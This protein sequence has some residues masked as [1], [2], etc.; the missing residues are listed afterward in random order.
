M[1][2]AQVAVGLEENNQV[3]VV[4]LSTRGSACSAALPS[5]VKFV[6]RIEAS[7]LTLV[8]TEA[9]GLAVLD[10]SGTLRYITSVSTANVARVLHRSRR[11][12]V[13]TRS[14]SLQLVDLD[15]GVILKDAERHTLQVLDLYACADDS[16][17]ISASQDW[18][19]CISTC[20]DLS[21]VRVLLGHQDGVKACVAVRGGLF[22]TSSYDRLLKVWSPFEEDCRVTLPKQNGVVVALASHPSRD[23]FASG[24]H[25][26]AV[27][28]WSLTDWS[29]VRS[30]SLAKSVHSLAFAVSQD[31]VLAGVYATGV[32]S[33]SWT[34]GTCQTHLP[35]SKAVW[36]LVCGEFSAL[37]L[38]SRLNTRDFKRF[39][40]LVRGQDCR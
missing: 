40:L 23:M 32:M 31:L 18:T 9:H 34:T 27:I 13:G 7:R 12:I 26:G 5:A 15:S 10:D 30:F 35:T 29:T 19:A 16:L 8:V 20:S 28:L 3:Y 36:G 22:V 1:S 38:Y 24:S 11:T 33:C 21:I 25:D 6:D 14:G 4:D 2:A 17:F 37:I 39:L